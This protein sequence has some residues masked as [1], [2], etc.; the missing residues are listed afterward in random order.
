MKSLHSPNKKHS[1]TF[2][3]YLIENEG[4]SKAGKE[5]SLEEVWQEYTGRVDTVMQEKAD[6][7]FSRRDSMAIR[8]IANDE[9]RELFPFGYAVSF[10]PEE[11]KEDRWVLRER[12]EYLTS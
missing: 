11:F 12:L 4:I 5:F 7:E 6:K 2:L 8:S 10:S 1:I 3:K 9:S